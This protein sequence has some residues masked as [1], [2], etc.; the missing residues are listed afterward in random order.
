[1]HKYL[2]SKN[3]ALKLFRKQYETGYIESSVDPDQLAL[4]PANQD[5]HCFVFVYTM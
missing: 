5:L 3:K 4:K 2:V 1:M